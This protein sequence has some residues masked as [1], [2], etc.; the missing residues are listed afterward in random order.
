MELDLKIQLGNAAMET[1][2]DVAD[3]ARGYVRGR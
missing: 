2:E 3:P 1:R